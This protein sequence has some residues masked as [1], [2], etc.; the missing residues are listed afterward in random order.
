MGLYTP[1]GQTSHHTIK[2]H[3][4]LLYAVT[5][6]DLSCLTY[7]HVRSS[8]KSIS[9]HRRVTVAPRWEDL[10]V[11]AP[12][13]C[14]K[15]GSVGGAVYIYINPGGKD[16]E[17]I[18]PVRLNGN[19][20]SMFGLAVENIGDVNQDGYGGKIEGDFHFNIDLESQKKK[21]E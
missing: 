13:F 6:S 21:E 3:K 4:T 5:F 17:N 12:Q 16:W 11:G 8:L 18:V 2:W 15:N 20:D 14:V 10:A 1:L 9:Q 19:E 7:A